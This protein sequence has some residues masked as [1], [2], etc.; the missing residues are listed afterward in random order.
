MHRVIHA[1][2]KPVINLY[3]RF[4]L[5]IRKLDNLNLNYFNLNLCTYIADFSYIFHIVISFL[6]VLEEIAKEAII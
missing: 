6:I 5:F 2:N 3:F 4:E 1:I